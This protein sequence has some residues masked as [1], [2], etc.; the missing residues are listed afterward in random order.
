VSLH[1]NLIEAAPAKKERSMVVMFSLLLVVWSTQLAA[2]GPST[3]LARYVGSY[4]T[5]SH[6]LVRVL[7]WKGQLVMAGLTG[8]ATP[9]ALE[10]GMT[11][12]APGGVRVEFGTDGRGTV[13][14]VIVY[15][16]SKLTRASR[17]L[18]SRAV[19]ESYVGTYRTL[20]GFAFVITF[21]RD[22][23]TV[24]VSNQP[25]LTMWPETF[26]TFYVLD[27]ASAELAEFEFV[28]DPGGGRPCVVLRQNGAGDKACPVIMENT[29]C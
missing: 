3:D 22:Q 11:F 21:E 26:R 10:A 24:Q 20:T 18:V 2:Q 5:E 15:D 19:L 28:A 16:G 14:Q 25:K 6:A 13:S 17:V 29:T 1:R 12:T 27:A 8:A 9:L 23:L 4:T 7:L